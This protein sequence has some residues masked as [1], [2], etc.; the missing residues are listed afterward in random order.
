[1]NTD[2]SQ[3]ALPTTRLIRAAKHALGAGCE[4]R[5]PGN[6]SQPLD[7]VMGDVANQLLAFHADLV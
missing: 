5:V 1:V 4:A 6:A 3:Q 7:R 2:A